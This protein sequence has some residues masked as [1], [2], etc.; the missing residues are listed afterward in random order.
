MKKKLAIL[1]AMAAM[2]TAALAASPASADNDRDFDGVGR[3]HGYPIYGGGVVDDV[4]YEN[5]GERS[6]LDGECFVEDVD[7]DGLVAEW[8][9]TCYY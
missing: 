9:I 1:A 6:R 7:L 2:T 4:D 8:E 3:Y 5:V